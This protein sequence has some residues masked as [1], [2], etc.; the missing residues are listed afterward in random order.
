MKQKL[1]YKGFFPQVFTTLYILDYG[2]N[3][4][5]ILAKFVYTIN[6]TATQT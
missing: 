5:A 4:Q 3:T 6:N 1:G 2:S